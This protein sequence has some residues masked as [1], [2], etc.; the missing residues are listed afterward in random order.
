MATNDINVGVIGYGWAAGAHVDAINTIP[1]AQVAGIYSSRPLD[2][3]QISARHGAEIRLYAS[4]ESMLADP[5]LHVV[6]ICSVHSQHAAQAIQA[7][8][9]G[10]HLIIEKPVAL[11]LDDCLDVER[12]VE[13]AGVKACVCFE[14]RFSS[15]FQATKALIDQGLLGRIHYGEVDYYHGIGP[16][17][18]QYEWNVRKEHAGSSLLTAG[19]HALDGLLLFM[20][21]DV[22]EV[23]ACATG[24]ANADFA[25]YQ[26]ETT[27]VTLLRYGDG[28]VG[29]VASCIDCLQPYYFHVHLVGSEGSLLDNRFSTT[30]LKGVDRGT[31]NMLSM[32]MLDSGDV[33]DHPYRA[34][35]EAFFSSLREGT[36]MQLTSLREAMRT[37]R[38]AFAAERSIQ[39]GRGVRLNEAAG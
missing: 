38:V 24:S 9:A 17:Y 12:A 15:Q 35:F 30:R 11:T 2:A 6:S 1:G 34:Q 3:G 31:W 33:T 5:A 26:Y 29:K 10:K 4:L 7:A 32:K 14:C 20:G 22:E 39:T 21:T 16:W 25:K 27:S 28:R 13:A 19:C 18:R 8:A 36:E 23:T 37:H